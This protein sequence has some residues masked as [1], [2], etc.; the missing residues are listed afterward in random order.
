MTNTSLNNV[1]ILCVDNYIDSLELLKLSLELCGA[2]VYAAVSMEEA[3]RIFRK[4]RPNMLVS[5]LALPQGNGISLLKTIRG[6]AP[7]IAAIALTAISDSK[8]RQQAMDAGFD[9]YL[10][11]PVDYDVLIEAV[12]A[13]ASKAG[14]LSA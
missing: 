3:M 10:V 11:K 2:Q 4:H 1:S 6:Q 9:R 13:L 8:V 5:D 14:K 7:G 12:S